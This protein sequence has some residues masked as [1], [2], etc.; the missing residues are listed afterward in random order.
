MDQN[1]MT[2]LMWASYRSF[3]IDPLRLILNF[4]ASVNYCD[5]NYKNTGLYNVFLS[6]F[7]ITL[8]YFTCPISVLCHLKFEDLKSDLHLTFYTFHTFQ[9]C[10]GRSLHRTQTQCLH[11]SKA[12]HHSK[13]PIIKVKHQQI[14]RMNGKII[15]SDT[16]LKKNTP[17]EVMGVQVSS[18]IFSL[19]LYVFSFKF[20]WNLSSRQFWIIHYTPIFLNTN[21]FSNYSHV[22]I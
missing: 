2:P 1:G 4:G 8:G 18:K 16:R 14:W 3:G 13:P 9:R 10:I 6:I 12:V 7:E 22:H 15:I 20:F 5:S 21:T 19:M 17:R 11:S